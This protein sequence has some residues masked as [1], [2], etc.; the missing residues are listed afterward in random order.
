MA[1]TPQKAY[2]HSANPVGPDGQ[3]RCFK[4][5]EVAV[6]LTSRTAANPGR[7]FYRCPKQANEKC[8]FF[9]WADDPVFQAHL[10]APGLANDQPP[11]PHVKQPS[12]T[13]G[14]SG[15][16]QEDRAILTPAPPLQA[17]PNKRPRPVSP[18]RPDGPTLS[19]SQG[20][21]STAPAG[22]SR[23][24]VAVTAPSVFTPSQR[25]RLMDNIDAA[26]KDAKGLTGTHSSPRIADTVDDSRVSWT[27][28]LFHSHGTSSDNAQ[29]RATADESEGQAH[30]ENFN[31]AL[32]PS[33]KR[34]RYGDYDSESGPPSPQ[35]SLYS[36]GIQ[37]SPI[38]SSE[39]EFA[40]D[41]A[42]L[43]HGEDDEETEFW[44]SPRPAG[45]TLLSHY[46][47]VPSIPYRLPDVVPQ[48]P[49]FRPHLRASRALRSLH[50]I[51]IHQ[52]TSS[53]LIVRVDGKVRAET[54]AVA[55]PNG[56]RSRLTQKARIPVGPLFY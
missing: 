8:S 23:V 7:Q 25:Q 18:S 42:S 31:L 53:P 50:W 48:T 14:A 2:H 16:P 21:V 20:R 46:D 36:A 33:P 6:K 52:P 22:S 13:P 35:P 49:A 29:F 4:H 19:S 12:S 10:G 45:S 24:G 3:V 26:L 1:S 39:S 47:T 41:D 34:S 27:S 32:P 56:A 51:L 11:T 5:G 55:H 43:F 54:S 17:S 38:P 9:Y 37:T 30:Q 44:C 28:S 40:P 15:I